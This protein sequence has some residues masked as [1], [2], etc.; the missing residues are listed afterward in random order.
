MLQFRPIGFTAGIVCTSIWMFGGVNSTISPES[1]GV[2]TSRSQDDHTVIKNKKPR[3]DHPVAIKHSPEDQEC[4]SKNIYHEAGVESKLGKLA[5]G[6]V[7]LNRLQTKRWG[8]SICQVVYYKSQFSWTKMKNKLDE[9]PKG[10]L[11]EESK[12]AAAQILRGV[13]VNALRGSLFYHTDYIATPKW[14]D[15]KA[16]II[17]IEQ[18]IFYTKALMAKPPKCKNDQI[19]CKTVKNNTI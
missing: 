18:H 7:T 12:Q 3:V 17:Q 14:V 16:K 1:T 5:V 4:L 11:W 10:R 8:D 15:R 13:R 19:K 2:I 9:T 6:Q